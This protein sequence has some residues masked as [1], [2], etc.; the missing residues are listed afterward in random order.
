MNNQVHVHVYMCLVLVMFFL[1]F[2]NAHMDMYGHM[3]R[4]THNI[5][6][7]ITRAASNPTISSKSQGVNWNK[8][9]NE[10]LTM[11]MRKLMKFGILKRGN[12]M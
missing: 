6:H 1:C 3:H 12:K 8:E 10:C 4:Q 5:V 7:K 2:L 9:T 11:K